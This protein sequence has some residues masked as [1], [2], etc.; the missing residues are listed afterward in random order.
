MKDKCLAIIP[1]RGGSKRIPRKNIKEFCG[2]PIIAYS[3]KSAQQTN[4]FSEVMVSTDDEEI[5][6]ISKQYG[7]SV[8][9]KRSDET[10]NDF[11]GIAD[12]LQEV[13][14]E[15]AKRGI[16]FDYLC[17]ILSTAPFVNSEKIIEAYNLLTRK[18]Y[19][20]VLAVASFNSPI[21]RALQIYN[22]RVS[23]IWPENYSKRSQDL[24]VSYHDTGQFYWIS[25]KQFIQ[26]KVF[27][28]DRTGAVILSEMEMQDID[29]EEDWIIAE[30]KYQY[31]I[32]K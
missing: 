9:F 11:A 2:E 29:T 26:N 19:D 3:I 16:T 4:L 21:F 8:P 28:T 24:P 13:L 27:F 18:S 10:S 15:Y 7:A 30:M 23:M 20:S 1:A 17:C 32:K 25:V 5:M 6:Q 22:N 14:E 12:V 31:Q